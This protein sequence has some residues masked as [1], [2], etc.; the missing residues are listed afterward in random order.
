MSM[1]SQQPG[2]GSITGIGYNGALCGY[3]YWNGGSAS[4]STTSA[5]CSFVLPPGVH[6]FGFCTSPSVSWLKGTITVLPNE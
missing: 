4:T 5:S 2:P 1:I 6:S 3:D